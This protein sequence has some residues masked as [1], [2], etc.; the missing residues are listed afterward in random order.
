MLDY[1]VPQCT[2]PCDALPYWAVIGYNALNC[3]DP[4]SML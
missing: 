2:I 1:K 3:I 4:L